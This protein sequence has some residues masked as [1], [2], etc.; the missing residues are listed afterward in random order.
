M[1]ATLEMKELMY[2]LNKVQP[3][4]VGPI[5]SILCSHSFVKASIMEDVVG[6]WS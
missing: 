6:D 5:H 1:P 2:W 3:F 4:I